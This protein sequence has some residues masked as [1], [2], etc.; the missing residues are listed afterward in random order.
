MLSTSTIYRA[1]RRV[2]FSG[3][4]AREKLRCRG[5]NRNCV[6]HDT[7]IRPTRLIPERPDA[8]KARARLGDVEGDTVCGGIGK[9]LLVTLV[10]RRSRFLLAG[11]LSNRNAAET[12]AVMQQ[13][14]TEYTVRSISLDNGTEFAE[15]WL[16]EEHIGA[17]VYF[18]KLYKPWQRGT[19]ENANG[20]LRFF[21]PQGL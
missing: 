19:N 10:D 4:S 15:F 1:V 6:H 17:P 5:K 8:V 18:A 7:A 21:L 12:R 2:T 9:G 14:L 13:P 16:L 20:I 3:I 11:K